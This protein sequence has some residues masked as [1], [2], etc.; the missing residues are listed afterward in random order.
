MLPQIPICVPRGDE[1]HYE[2]EHSFF[3]WRSESDPL[4]IALH[5]AQDSDAQA[6]M[7]ERFM[8]L[9]RLYVTMFPC[10]ECAKLLI[11]AGITE[12][13][14]YEVS[15]AVL[16]PILLLMACLCIPCRVCLYLTLLLLR[17]S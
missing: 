12:V 15:I 13:V 14:F 16:L 4:L 3:I 9:Q 10:N 5:T 1:R 11:Q 8:V 7:C 17:L 2:Q 6:T